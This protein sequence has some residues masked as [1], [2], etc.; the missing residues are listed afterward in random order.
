MGDTKDLQG[1]FI[2]HSFL[3]QIV[4]VIIVKNVLPEEQIWWVFGDTWG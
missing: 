4:K 1:H 2:S 3:L